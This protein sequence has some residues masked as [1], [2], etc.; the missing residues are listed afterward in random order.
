[1]KITSL[2]NKKMVVML[3]SLLLLG[4]AVSIC[5][6]NNTIEIRTQEKADLIPEFIKMLKSG[7]LRLSQIADELHTKIK[8]NKNQY[9]ASHVKMIEKLKNLYLNKKRVG[10]L[11]L[12]LT[13]MEFR[14]E[15]PSNI[16]SSELTKYLKKAL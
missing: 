4:S 8:K 16:D 7:K 11:K 10:I 13:F 5:T 12:G 2:K 14:N 9:K 3:A 15:F 1:M 6:D